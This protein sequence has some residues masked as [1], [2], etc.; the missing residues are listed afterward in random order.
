LS[1][2]DKT[3]YQLITLRQIVSGLGAHRNWWPDESQLTQRRDYLG[4]VV[5]KTKELA[6]FVLESE[7]A[8]QYHD[9]AVGPGQYH[10]FRLSEDLERSI[11]Q[12]FRQEASQFAL[13]QTK[14]GELLARLAG[15]AANQAAEPHP[16][17]V[18]LGS[19]QDI[20]DDT[21]LAVL[22]R[23][24]QLAFSSGHRVFPYLT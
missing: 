20:D 17:P 6:A 13:D 11:Y 1:E 8:R 15:L 19:I 21:T 14:P 18:L 22:A 5:P 10:L 23:H 9:Q 3:V 4:Y 24:Y 12:T 7:I 16:G 2:Q